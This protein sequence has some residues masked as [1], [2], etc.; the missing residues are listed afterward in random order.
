MQAAELQ[1]RL[2]E[3]QGKKDDHA[4]FQEEMAQARDEAFDS[5]HAALGM[6]NP[7][8]PL[9]DLNAARYYLAY[10]YWIREDPYRAAVLGDFLARRYP[11]SV[12]AR[13][14]AKI[15]MAA[16]A[17]LAA[18]T[19]SDVQR[20]FA[21]AQMVAT[22]DF[23]TRRWP[24]GPEAADA[25]MTLLR[26]AIVGG[27]VGAARGLLEK[28]PPDSP[29][30]ADAELTLGRALWA[31]YLQA[32]QMDD[33]ERPGAEELDKMLAEARGLL[34]GGID[35]A[36]KAGEVDS[37][38]FAA[39]LAL[40]QIHLHDGKAAEAVKLLEDPRIGPVTLVGAKHPA[41]AK[42]GYAVETY[43]AALRAY[44]AAGQLEK[45][46]KTMDALE[47]MVKQT[48]DAGASSKLTQIYISLG[49]ELQELLE[50][51]RKQKKTEQLAEV[52][53]GFELFLNRISERQQGNTFNSLNWVAETFLGMGAGFDPGGSPL[54]PEAGKYYQKAADTY[55]DILKRCDADAS[56]APQP[57]A[58]DGIKVRLA[59]CMRRFGRHD[60]AMKL[61]VEVLKYRNMMVDAQ[62][63]AAYTYQAWAATPGNAKRYLSAIVGGYRAKK[64]DGSTVNLVW[65]WGRI[66]KLVAQS[67]KYLDVFHEARYNLAL[68]RFEYALS[69]DG[70]DKTKTLETAKNDVTIIQRLYPDMGGEAWRGK[71]DALLKKIQGLLGEKQ[72]GLG[73]K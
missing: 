16:Y 24:D 32:M 70:A 53:G 19:P 27:N 60:E 41:A 31:R 47:A 35:R 22:A 25:F 43:K 29:R 54:P 73:G 36:S 30:R 55:G 61:L 38:L 40:A 68:C 5:Y 51:L 64:K 50:S 13:Q 21:H 2:D 10:L 71:Y 17:K 12:G 14:G 65:G 66:A 46:E 7:D 48:G 3:S 34:A 44:V 63:Q 28:L 9:E 33:A 57:E 62:V 37:S 1:D 45:A 42:E 18:E 20:D 52:S 6:A 8:T 26:T 39:A 15:A 49:R 11:E 69:L 4:R 58:T 59:Q 72:V 67:P 23:I 56:F